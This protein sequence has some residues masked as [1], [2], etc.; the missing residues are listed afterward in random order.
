[1]D[2]AL[3]GQMSREK[4]R[5]SM[6]ESNSGNGNGNNTND[7]G[8]ETRNFT[9]QNGTE[10]APTGHTEEFRVSGEDIMARIKEIVEAGNARRIIVRNP[11][12]RNVM[13]VS[14]T[15]GLIGT[16]LLGVSA[17]IGAVLA[18]AC[19]YTIVV[20]KREP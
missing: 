4:R 19:N 20:E 3:Y 14:L 1:M 9:G 5:T 8:A 6:N 2:I 16:A 17:A 12:G 7:G 13:E 10:G 11:E 18:L 15:A